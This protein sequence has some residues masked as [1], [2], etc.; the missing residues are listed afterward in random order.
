MFYTPHIDAPADPAFSRHAANLSPAVTLASPPDRASITTGDDRFQDRMNLLRKTF[1]QARNQRLRD[2]PDDSVS[3]FL[4][5]EL[6]VHRNNFFGSS[7]GGRSSSNGSRGERGGGGGSAGVWGGTSSDVPAAAGGAGLVQWSRARGRGRQPPDCWAH[8]G[9][10]SGA[11]FGR[12]RNVLSLGN[13]QGAA[14]AAAA[15]AAA[16]AEESVSAPPPSSPPRKREVVTAAAA[17]AAAADRAAAAEELIVA[18]H[19]PPAG[20]AR[21]ATGAAA[22]PAESGGGA[23]RRDGGSR[24]SSSVGGAQQRQREDE[25]EEEKQQKARGSETTPRQPPAGVDAAGEWGATSRSNLGPMPTDSS[26]GIGMRSGGIGVR[27]TSALLDKL[28]H[29]QDR[30]QAVSETRAQQS[31]QVSM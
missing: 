7:W 6:S 3:A 17:A 15:T 26:K 25:Q 30:G 20:Q 5:D 22:P 16:A 31:T 12:S 27:S 23:S 24:S 2:V 21:S 13:L 10:A 14:M 8:V 28:A 1:T 11:L 9:G 4:G 19:G 18:A 29:E